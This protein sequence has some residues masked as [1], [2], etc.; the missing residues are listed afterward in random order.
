MRCRV[1]S[2][3][4]FTKS[5]PRSFTRSHLLARMTTPRPA[6]SASPPIAAS[7]S[8]APGAGVDHQRDDV[9][10]EDR[11]LRAGDAD[12]LHLSAAAHASRLP[13][14]GRVDD[15]EAAAM[16]REHRVDGVAGRARHVADQHALLAQQPVDQRRL[17][18]IRAARRWRRRSHRGFGIRDL[19]FG[20]SSS[21]FASPRVPNPESRGAC[22]ISSSSSATPCPCSAEISTTGSNP[23]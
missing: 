9:G 6:R 20:S 19:G 23:S 13:H 8:V 18:H 3:N 7:C 14:A 21:D 17:A 10:V 4:T 1:S 2:S 5:A 12:H 16:P 15:A 22:T 11:F